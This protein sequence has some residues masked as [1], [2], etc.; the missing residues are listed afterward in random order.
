MF[1]SL[2]GGGGMYFPTFHFSVVG[3][4]LAHEHGCCFAVERVGRVGV[5]EELREE[6]LE[7][8]DHVV[9]G[10]PGLVDD[11]EADGAGAGWG[12][13][14]GELGQ[15]MGKIGRLGNNGTYSSSMFG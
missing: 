9:H 14:K 13:T 3:L 2:T 12:E 15:V 1:K 11:V 10:G 4:G 6:D 8:V 5:A 7:D